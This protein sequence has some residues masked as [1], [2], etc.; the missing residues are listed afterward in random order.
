MLFHFLLDASLENPR[1]KPHANLH[2][3]FLENIFRSHFKE[4]VR[5]IFTFTPSVPKGKH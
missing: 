4:R 5:H 3:A 1:D 2:A